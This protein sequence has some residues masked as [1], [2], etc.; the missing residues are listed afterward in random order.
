MAVYNMDT[1]LAISGKA[2]TA[3]AQKHT[4]D[5]IF[6]DCMMPKMA[7]NYQTEEITER[8]NTHFKD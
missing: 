5:I 6:M 3:L 7:E 8:L 2:A 1:K 4:Y